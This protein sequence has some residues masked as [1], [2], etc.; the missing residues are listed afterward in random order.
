MA[1][2]HAVSL[3]RKDGSK[4]IFHVYGGPMPKRN[5][6]ITLPVDGR[7]TNA[8][9]LRRIHNIETPADEAVAVEALEA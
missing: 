8:R 4:R 1:D 3:L 2:Q 7:L 6:L 9:V 5:N